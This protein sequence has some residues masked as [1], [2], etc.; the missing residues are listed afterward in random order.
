MYEIPASMEHIHVMYISLFKLSLR[1]GDMI[2]FIRIHTEMIPFGVRIICQ[3]HYLE[4]G[5]FF[6]SF[7]LFENIFL[8][9]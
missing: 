5:T 7:S 4:S 2:C 1:R 6:S 9:Y 3:S 8:K